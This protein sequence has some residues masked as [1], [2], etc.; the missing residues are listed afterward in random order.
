M[1]VPCL[2][3]PVGN[4]AEQKPDQEQAVAEPQDRRKQ[5]EENGFD[6]QSG[7]KACS[8]AKG[9]PQFGTRQNVDRGGDLR[10][11]PHREQ[12]EQQHPTEVG[13]QHGGGIAR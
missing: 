13:A 4:A 7:R 5:Q 8:T 12:A 9:P 10:R 3:A 2:A 1:L 6:Q 11:K